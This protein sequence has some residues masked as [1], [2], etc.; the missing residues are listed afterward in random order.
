MRYKVEI[1]N[2]DGRIAHILEKINSSKISK[3]NKELILGF[4]RNRLSC[5]LSKARQYKYLYTLERITR[6]LTKDFEKAT[7]DDIIEL[8]A[9]FEKGSFSEWSKHDC[10]PLTPLDV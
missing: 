5:G 7:K 1:Y 6:I 2:Y 8:V 3:R 9:H 10:P 4:H